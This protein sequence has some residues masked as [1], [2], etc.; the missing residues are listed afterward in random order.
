MAAFW[1][2][3]VVAGLGALHGLN[4]IG[5]WLWAAGCGLRS[6]DPKRA[7]RAL[8]PIALGHAAS[9]VMVA[10]A[11]SAA[12]SRGLAMGSGLLLVGA[13]GLVVFAALHL[14]RRQSGAGAGL[15]LMSFLVSTA[16]GGGLMLVPALV[17]LCMGE[18]AVREITVSGAWVPVLSAVA[19][20]AAAMLAV[21]GL[22]SAA[23]CSVAKR[24][25]TD[26]RKRNT[27]HVR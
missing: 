5:G 21:T 19:L 11:V 14:A 8:G 27:F 17:P 2:W 15:T 3:L 26:S 13:V 22:M 24:Y 18:G 16:Q 7:W 6:R 10:L 1:P 9:L 25:W 4:P 12:L 20:H 23:A